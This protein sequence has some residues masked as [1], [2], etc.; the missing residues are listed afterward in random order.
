MTKVKLHSY[1]WIVWFIAALFYG[2]DFFQRVAPSVV[3]EPMIGSLHISAVT[4]SVIISFYFYAYAAAQIPVGIVLDKF[5]ARKS[6]TAAAI[7]VAVGTLLFALTQH[8][9]VLIAGRL[10]VG[11][12]SAFAFVGCLKLATYWF[13]RNYFALIVGMTN[14]LGVI[15]ALFGEEPLSYFITRYGWQK[16]LILSAVFGFVVALLIALFVRNRPKEMPTPAHPCCRQQHSVGQILLSIIKKPQSWLVSVYA[17]LM[18]APVIAFAEL[19]AVPFLESTHHLTSHAASGIDSIVFIGIAIGGPFNGFISRFFKQR[20]TVMFIGNIVA[21]ASLVT[22]IVDS[23]TPIVI[24][25]AL[26]FIYGFATSSMLLCFSI[27]SDHHSADHSANVIAFTN[28]IIMAI[29]AIFQTSVGYLFSKLLANIYSVHFNEKSLM[30]AI[31][32]LPITLLINLIL[33]FFIRDFN[34]NSVQATI[35][36]EEAYNES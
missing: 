22:I 23:H 6:L 24:L 14:T 16:S 21:L 8:V 15:G 5:G 19:W 11:V 4:L 20:K 7:C 35:Q 34:K 27:N 17:G 12:G 25:Q 18:V 31:A 10:L 1:A 33:L 29:G 32:I 30:L 3:V 13:P 2:V 36:I 9:A 28:T 26:F